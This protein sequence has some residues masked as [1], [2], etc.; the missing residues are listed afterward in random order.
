MVSQKKSLAEAGLI[1]RQN[2][3]PPPQPE[4]KKGKKSPQEPLL[5]IAL[6]ENERLSTIVF[7]LPSTFINWKIKKK[8]KIK[9]YARRQRSVSA[10]R[11]SWN[12]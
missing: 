2:E 3:P 7:G 9:C 8:S 5:E 6:D 10:G 12:I 11:E 4:P 1:I